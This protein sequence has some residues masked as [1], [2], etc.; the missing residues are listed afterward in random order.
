MVAS[1]GFGYKPSGFPVQKVAIGSGVVV[2]GRVVVGLGGKPIRVIQ[3][4]V[5]A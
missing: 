4:Y 2:G 3:Y 1:V 5:T